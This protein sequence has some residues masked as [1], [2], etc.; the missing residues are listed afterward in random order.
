MWGDKN[1]DINQRKNAI[2]DQIVFSRNRVKPRQ[3]QLCCHHLSGPC[4]ACGPSII[5]YCSA[6]YMHNFC[7]QQCK[8]R[9]HYTFEPVCEKFWLASMANHLARENLLVEIQIVA[10]IQVDLAFMQYQIYW[11]EWKV[12]QDTTCITRRVFHHIHQHPSIQLV[13]W[14]YASGHSFFPQTITSLKL[15]KLVC[16]TDIQIL[17]FCSGS[18]CQHG[19]DKKTKRRSN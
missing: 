3:D 13:L 19:L 12:T 11:A 9:W 15:S 16:S 14:T 8:R 4:N 5:C 2:I 6:E 7:S 18:H 10:T 1:Q 17:P